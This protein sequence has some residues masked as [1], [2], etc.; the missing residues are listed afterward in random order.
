ME[1]DYKT[2]GFPVDGTGSLCPECASFLSSTTT[3]QP[4]WPTTLLLVPTPTHYLYHTTMS[5]AGSQD[6]DRKPKP[7]GESRNLLPTRI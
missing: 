3:A 2:V 4:T 1:F 7:E 5:D 6:G